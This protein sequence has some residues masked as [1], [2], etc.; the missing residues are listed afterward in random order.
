M[1]KI[2]F[3]FFISIMLSSS[4]AFA[5]KGSHKIGVFP[6]PPDIT[7]SVKFSEPS[8]NNILDAEETG[9]LTI[10]VKNS[11]KGDAFDVKAEISSDKNIRG[12]SFERT[13]SFG[14]IPAGKS[15][16]AEVKLKSSENISTDNVSFTIHIKEANGFDADPLKI[17]FKTKSF[18]PPKLV[19]AD[20]GIEDQN[21]NSKVEQMENVEMTVRIQNM[22]YGDARD[23]TVD[24][25]HGN[26]VFIGGQGITHFEPGS[27]QAGKY[28]DI[29]FMFYTN[30]QIKNGERI[31]IE[32][33]IKEARPQFAL[34]KALDLAMNAPQK[35]TEEIIV[36]GEEA[37]KKA[38]MEL[39]TGL[40]VDVDMQI[41]AG[42]NAGKYDIAV[43]IGNRHYTSS[44]VPEVEFADRDARI[45]KEYL[46]TTF[47]YKPENIIYE[48][49]ATLSRFNEIFG[50]K[51][52]PNGKLYNYIKKD[53]SNVFVYYAGHGAPDLNSQEAYFVPVDANPQYMAANGYRLQTFYD[54][55]S[56]LPAK[57]VTIVLDSCFSG[58]TQKGMLFKNISPAMVKV[59]KQYS[60][61]QNATIIT[62]A[63]VDEVSAWYG[64]KKHSL[65]TYYFLKGLQGNAD[66]NSDSKI[67][68]GEMKQY[69]KENVSY[70]ARRVA[71][72]EQNPVIS[73]NENELL[74]TISK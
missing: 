8:G 42:K 9:I 25:V 44:G 46:M 48:E 59:K 66:S 43:V 6:A 41:P 56:K 67:T 74:V 5:E 28:K 50:S 30:K 23:V 29:K 70:M 73:G 36:K 22:G 14:A 1:L 11:G 54:N 68:V 33:K 62:S 52:N 32:I 65:F 45:M 55:L 39:A 15:N 60:G 49:D 31:P 64:E 3:S 10:T 13:F 16:T 24:I 19:I 4:L 37:P 21:G 51:D 26:N 47:G 7:A 63:A 53:V 71:G 72:T 2:I 69:L 20:I 61:P 18:E 57:N 12:L 35:R 38:D 27:I 17:A 34:S 40:S 58:N